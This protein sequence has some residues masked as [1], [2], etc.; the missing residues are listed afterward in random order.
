MPPIIRGAEI[1]FRFRKMTNIE[2]TPAGGTYQAFHAYSENF[3]PGEGLVDDDELGGSRHNLVDPTQQ[4][5]DLP[6]PSGSMTVPLDRNQIG[7]WL[8]SMWGAPTTTG[9]GP[10]YQHVWRSGLT[11]PGLVS[12]EMPL[13][14]NLVR[15]ADAGCVSGLRLDMGDQGGFR[16]AELDFALRSVRQLGAALSA[17]VTP[18]PARDKI[19]AWRGVCK[20]NGVNLG[21][22]LGGNVQM[23]N[24]AFFER[25]FDDSEW[26]SAVEIGRPMFSASPQLRVRSDAAAMLAQ[27][28]GVTPFAF[29][30]LFQVS[31][32]QSL[33]IEAPNVVASPVIPS[34]QGLGPMDV[35]PTFMASQTASAAML[36]ITLN[37]QTASY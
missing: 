37:N 36:T 32:N 11:A 8:S 34:S 23:G 4:A 19:A 5:K 33:K 3:Q 15:I 9:A 1:Q 24:G 26:P 27:F 6:N 13:A 28:D 22:V 30:L 20:I 10:N 31:A 29:E 16:K 25:Y 21:N 18:A 7:Y 2:A 14:A 12:I 35:T 17:S